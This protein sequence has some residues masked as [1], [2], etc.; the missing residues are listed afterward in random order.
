MSRNHYAS[1]RKTAHEIAEMWPASRA[2]TRKETEEEHMRYDNATRVFIADIQRKNPLIGTE[3]TQGPMPFGIRLM[4]RSCHIASL[5]ARQDNA[6]VEELV[7]VLRNPASF[8]TLETLL[9]QG[10]H[11]T[12][13]AETALGLTPTYD[14]VHADY[15]D[16]W[17]I[18]GNVLSVPTIGQITED[19]RH[20]LEER[21]CK[22]SNGICPAHRA[23][24]VEPLFQDIVTI[25]ERDKN[26]FERSITEK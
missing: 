26:L 19:A 2:A 18:T 7:D 1:L 24:I 3:M 8:N 5:V 21:G 12:D 20:Q 10:K 22:P 6:S 9:H 4:F 16:K 15:Q 11:I 13:L 25:C 17:S 23:K 14:P